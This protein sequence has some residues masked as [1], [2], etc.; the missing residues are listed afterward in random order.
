MHATT[1]WLPR[2]RQREKVKGRQLPAL[3]Y[4]FGKQAS[5]LLPSPSNFLALV[6]P[7]RSQAAR[8]TPVNKLSHQVWLN[9]MFSKFSASV[10]RHASKLFIINSKRTRI[11][12]AVT[13]RSR[14][15]CSLVL[16]HRSF[17]FRSLLVTGVKERFLPNRPFMKILISCLTW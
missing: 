15:D 13:P 2:N 6:K 16:G 9:G 17:T 1:S 8:C 10:V 3:F 4:S 7:R 14:R 12:R 5:P 11:S